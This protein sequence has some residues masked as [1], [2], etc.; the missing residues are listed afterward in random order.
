MDAAQPHAGG[1]AQKENPLRNITLKNSVQMPI[2]GLGAYEIP[3][4]QTE[5]AVTDSLAAGCHDTALHRV[6]RHA[7]EWRSPWPTA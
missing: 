2:P 3:S 5:Q 7:E 6:P 4:E 1:P